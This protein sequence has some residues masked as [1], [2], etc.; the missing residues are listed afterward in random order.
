M[1]FDFH[2]SVHSKSESQATTISDVMRP[3]TGR[4]GSSRPGSQ[5]SS[6]FNKP[7]TL[8]KKEKTKKVS[9][10]DLLAM[11]RLEQASHVENREYPGVQ[12]T[13]IT[14]ITGEGEGTWPTSQF[15]QNENGWNR[16]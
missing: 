10:E 16:V 12:P 13:K 2:S 4:P 5:R 7:N 8:V 11:R 3:G 9:V 6:T 14:R 15:G 1:G